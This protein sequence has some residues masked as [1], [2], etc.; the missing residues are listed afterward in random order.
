MLSIEKY[1]EEGDI[2]FEIL[3]RQLNSLDKLQGYYSNDPIAQLNIDRLTP[4]EFNPVYHFSLEQYF[5]TIETF[6]Q[7][8]F[9]RYNRFRSYRI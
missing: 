4:K 6:N 9:F 2:D 1:Q 5:K 7:S 8:I 3:Q